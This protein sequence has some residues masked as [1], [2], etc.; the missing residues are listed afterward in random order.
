MSSIDARIVAFMLDIDQP[1]TRARIVNGCNENFG[2]RESDQLIKEHVGLLSGRG[3]LSEFDPEAESVFLDTLFEHDQH[4]SIDGTELSPMMADSY[5]TLGP[6]VVAF[7]QENHADLMSA[8]REA[9]F[10]KAGLVLEGIRPSFGH[11]GPFP[12]KTHIRPDEREKVVTLLKNAL[13]ELDGLDLPN[14]KSA[15]AKA[16]VEAAI[17][18]A[19]SPEPDVRIVWELIQRASHV[20]GV[21]SLFV[22]V[23]AIIMA[24]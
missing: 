4:G 21:A 5:L 2:P 22:A 16:Y 13:R 3:V 14:S 8:C 12:P 24:S 20:A 9:G 15:Q 7:A 11:K 6:H 19:N 23:L 17:I 10:D 18:L 1:C